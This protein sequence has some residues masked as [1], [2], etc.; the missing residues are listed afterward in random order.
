MVVVLFY[1]TYGKSSFEKQT[2]FSEQYFENGTI[3][4]FVALVFLLSRTN[5]YIGQ[6]SF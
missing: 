2:V 4:Y 6:N 3:Q 1:Q 5:Q